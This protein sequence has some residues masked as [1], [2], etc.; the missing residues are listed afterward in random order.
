MAVN[1]YMVFFFSANPRRFLDYWWAYCIIC[2]GV[3]LI[4][5]L[6]LLLLRSEDGGRVYGDATVSRQ[7]WPRNLPFI[8][9]GVNLTIL[10]IWCWIASDWKTLRILT[11]YL[12]IWVC[13]V[14]SICIYFAVGCYVFRLRNNLRNLSLSNPSHDAPAR[15]RESGEKVSLSLSCVTR[16]L[17]HDM[18]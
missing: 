14:L 1:V 3:P 7:I 13:I 11:Y 6:W 10:K 18:V 5:A 12:P 15:E 4:P 2:Y 9:N 16:P 17:P 8:G